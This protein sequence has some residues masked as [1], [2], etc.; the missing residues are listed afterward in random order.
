[1]TAALSDQGFTYANG[2]TVGFANTIPTTGT[3]AAGDIVLENKPGSALSGWKR[4]T[5]GANHVLGTD[6]VYFNYATQGSAPVFGARAWCVFN[7]TLTGTNAPISGSNVTSVTRNA[8][9]DYTVNFTAAMPDANYCV[10]L[11]CRNAST[12]TGSAPVMESG[13]D[14]TK[15]RV[16]TYLS[17]SG[18]SLDVAYVMLAIFR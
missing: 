6:W 15:V 10:S 9:G 13:S 8:V 17:S 4:Q 1:M 5:T 16:I 2:N 3:Y 12:A 11:S 14:A 18:A 7:G